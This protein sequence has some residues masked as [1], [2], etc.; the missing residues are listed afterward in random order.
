MFLAD[1]IPADTKLTADQQKLILGGEACMWAEQ[2]HEETVDSRVWPR[3]L[4]IAERLWSPQGDRDVAD[5]YRRLRI[6]SLELE[7]VG[8]THIS[9]PQK[10]RRNI[11][12]EQAPAAL[13]LLASVTE[14]VS[15]H[16]RYQG[17]HTDSLTSLDRMVDAVVADPPSRQE[18]AHA[19]DSYLNPG[20]R[21]EAEVMSVG[22]REHFKQWQQSAPRLAAVC[23]RTP[24]LS[25]VT[26]RAQQ[27]GQ[28]GTIGLEALG[29]LDQHVSPPA[30]WQTAQLAIL[31]EAGKNSGLIR[32][33]FLP[34]MRKL[35]EAAG[36]NQQK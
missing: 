26:T 18:I 19:V 21:S 11:A 35:V 15:F 10:L 36:A 30:G 31:D 12:G 33:T 2:I 24:R 25:D 17:Q 16:E 13:D 4:A 6:A 32:F 9:G 27:L 8:L 14:P 28:L 5:M 29:Y 1:P 22:L 7:D 34:S 23:Q 20:S 3:A